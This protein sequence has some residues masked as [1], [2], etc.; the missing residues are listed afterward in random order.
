M[1]PGAERWGHRVASEGF[2]AITWL[3][4]DET[5]AQSPEGSGRFKKSLHSTTRRRTGARRDQVE[6][7][8]SPCVMAGRSLRVFASPLTVIAGLV[9]AIHVLLRARKSR[10]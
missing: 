8:F 1:A 2:D 9:P 10:G 7:G 6:I 4:I 5:V 3:R